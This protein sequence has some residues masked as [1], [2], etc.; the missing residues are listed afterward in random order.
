MPFVKVG[1]LSGLPPGSVMEAQVGDGTY[2]VCNAAGEVHALDGICPHAGGPLG[3][4]ALHGTTLV[5]PWHAWEFDCR[6][7]V[8]DSGASE[9]DDGLLV[10]KFPVRIDGDDILI[11]V[12]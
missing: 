4:G 1:S 8:K 10:A 12:P 9:M 7:Q 5:C 2:A 11:D 6:T 3:Q